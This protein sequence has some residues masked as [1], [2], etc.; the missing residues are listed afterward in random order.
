MGVNW[1]KEDQPGQWPPLTAMPPGVCVLISAHYSP[2]RHG[3]RYGIPHGT[4]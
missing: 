2:I 3:I 4:L 1:Q